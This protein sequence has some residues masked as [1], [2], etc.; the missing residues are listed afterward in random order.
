[1]TF[2]AAVKVE[3][4]PERLSGEAG[5]LLERE[6]D[7]RLGLTDSLAQKLRDPRHPALTVHPLVELLRARLYLIGGG[8]RDQDDA[9]KLRH[10][11]ALRLAVSARRGDAALK[12]ARGPQEPEG[13]GSQPTQSR[14]VAALAPEENRRVLREALL[15]WTARGVLARRGHRFQHVTMDFD[16]TML[17]VFGSQGGSAY[18]GH[19][20]CRGYHPLVAL[21][22]ET[23]DWVDGLLRSGEVWTAAGAVE[24]VLNVLARVEREIGLVARVRGDAGMVDEPMLTALEQRRNAQGHPAPSPYVF[25]LKT[26]AVLER[27]AEPFVSRP[28]GR[29]PLSGREWTHELEYQAEG[30][31]VPR[32]V[33]LVV[34]ERPFELFLDYF[35]LVTNIAPEQ[36]DGKGLLE[37][38]RPRG[39]MEGHLG[40]LKSALRPA[41]SCSE[42]QREKPRTDEE[43]KRADERD[44]ACNEATMLLYLLSYN[45]ANQARLLM[46]EAVPRPNSATTGHEPLPEPR[47][48]AAPARQGWSL[49]RFREQVL[50]TAARFLLGGR[51][52]TVVIAGAAAELWRCLWQRIERLRPLTV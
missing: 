49:L 44:A 22:A 15:D 5:A 27:M 40:E 21:I 29:P 17:A 14:L 12:P 31:R 30:W 24:F 41:L 16:S 26:N 43:R 4:R 7:E 46:E 19:Y 36:L 52:V 35:F 51:E 10:D 1:M 8:W 13:L 47:E 33:V 3:A 2:N 11:P 39:A 48:P 6:I 38:Y 37:S 25:R 20:L 45:L 9:D 42:R 23:G 50:K 32:R 18:N 28:A 34:I